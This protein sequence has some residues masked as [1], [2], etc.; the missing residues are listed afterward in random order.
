M[1][2]G[3]PRDSL[4]LFARGQHKRNNLW[5]YLRLIRMRRN[6]EIR[7]LTTSIKPELGSCDC[8]GTVFNRQVSADDSLGSQI[9]RQIFLGSLEK[10]QRG[11]GWY[12][13]RG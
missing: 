4:R 9:F 11:Y 12:F 10:C 2:S 6:M 7:D 8:V 3:S 5:S 13:V 1:P